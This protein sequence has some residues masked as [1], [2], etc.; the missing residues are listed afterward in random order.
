MRGR[1]RFP[2]TLA[3]LLT[4]S[5]ATALAAAT[6]LAAAAATV[7]GPGTP[8]ASGRLHHPTT[9]AGKVL[10]ERWNGSAWKLASAPSPG[11]S[12]I[13]RL[14]GVAATSASNA[15]AVGDYNPGGAYKSLIEHWNGSAWKQQTSPNPS[16]TDTFL[17]GVDA[18]S[19]SSAWAVGAYETG[20]VFD[21]LAV[22]WNGSSW[23]KVSTPNPSAT[24]SEF[25]GVAAVSASN[26]WAVGYYH[27]GS[28][29]QTLIE[30]WNGSTWKKVSSPDPGGSGRNNYL[31]GVSATSASN[32]WAVGEYANGTTDRT[33]ILHYNGTS[34]KQVSSPNAGGPTS[35]NDFFGVSASS[36]SNA[37]AVGSEGSSSKPQTL[38]EH[39]NGSSWKV[40]AS[41]D[42]G[43]SNANVLY[44]VAAGSSTTTWAVGSYFNGSKY[45][46]LIARWNGST[47]TQVASISGGSS[48]TD[49]DLFGVT[50][51]SSTSA[52]AVGGS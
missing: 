24:Q 33:L 44:G 42:P 48:S 46:T 50:A 29:D 49:S 37:W 25:A 39:W 13:S 17:V 36:A 51:T 35:P 41:P 32:V 23:K 11:G 20:S 1:G 31:T 8:P 47:W 5:A 7:G 22:R 2:V 3:A 4:A 14:F 45:V 16:S 10:V 26:A 28:K 27:N 40:V 12:G 38:T 18:T 21:T 43:G 52:W 6:P 30:H 34:W 19:A 9:G 15:W